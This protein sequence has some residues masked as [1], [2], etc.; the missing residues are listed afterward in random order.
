M[1]DVRQICQYL[2][3]SEVYR[4]RDVIGKVLGSLLVEIHPQ[5]ISIVSALGEL[6]QRYAISAPRADILTAL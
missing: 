1:S 2:A 4:W 3:V 6:K 5:D